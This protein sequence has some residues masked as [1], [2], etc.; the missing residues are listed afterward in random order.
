MKW[1]EDVLVWLVYRIF[2]GKEEETSQWADWPEPDART[3]DFEY[4]PLDV[5]MTQKLYESTESWNQHG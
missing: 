2:G 4:S 5:E 1:V 3:F